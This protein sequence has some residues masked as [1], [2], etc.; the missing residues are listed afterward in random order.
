MRHRPSMRL[1][2]AENRPRWESPTPRSC[3]RD[4][5]HFD[6]LADSCLADRRGCVKGVAASFV[7]HRDVGLHYAAYAGIG[8]RSGSDTP[9]RSPSKARFR[10]AIAKWP[11]RSD[12]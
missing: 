5:L 4:T 6:T 2:T 8:P 10:S 9:A 7:G 12:D 11:S 1:A 3:A